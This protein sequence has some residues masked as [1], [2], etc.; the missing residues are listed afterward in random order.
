MGALDGLEIVRQATYENGPMVNGVCEECGHE[1]LLASNYTQ[2]VCVDCYISHL[3][4]CETR[5]GTVTETFNNG[6]G[7]GNHPLTASAY[8]HGIFKGVRKAFTL[9]KA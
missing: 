8:M 6:F 1:A 3:D 5:W 4:Y 7:I 9:V 2:F